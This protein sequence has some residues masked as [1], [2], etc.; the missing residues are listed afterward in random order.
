MPPCA[1]KRLPKACK[2]GENA[3]DE[4][5]STATEPVVKWDR[6]PAADEGAA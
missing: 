3:G 6:Q 5:G 2:G 4:D 1:C